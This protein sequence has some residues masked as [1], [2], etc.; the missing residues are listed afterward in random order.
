MA[1]TDSS[2]ADRDK[3]AFARWDKRMRESRRPLLTKKIIA[4]QRGQSEVWGGCGREGGGRA[5]QPVIEP[6][7]WVEGLRGR[8][9]KFGA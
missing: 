6:G 3:I 1:D 8:C 5:I 9:G 4:V 7:P 2:P